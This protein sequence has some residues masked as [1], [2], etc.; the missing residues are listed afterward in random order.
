MAKRVCSVSNSEKGT[1]EG[2]M[3]DMRQPLRSLGRVTKE[4]MM[5]ARM[6]IPSR[7]MTKVRKDIDHRLRAGRGESSGERSLTIPA[8]EWSVVREG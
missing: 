5:L 7:A 1:Y 6:V 3:K 4:P 8:V 2:L